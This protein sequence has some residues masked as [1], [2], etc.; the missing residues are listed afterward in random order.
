MQRLVS[1]DKHEFTFMFFLEKHNDLSPFAVIN[2]Q[3][4]FDCR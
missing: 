1:C 4:S 2:A 3:S